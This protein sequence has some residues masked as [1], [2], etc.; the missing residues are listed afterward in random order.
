MYCFNNPKIKILL[1]VIDTRLDTT[2][3]TTS[4]CIRIKLSID[5]TIQDTAGDNKNIFCGGDR[6]QL[7][8][9]VDIIPIII[10]TLIIMT[11]TATTATRKKLCIGNNIT[12]AV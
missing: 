10:R 9:M 1:G 3:D 12:H 8:R 11:T 2:R 6:S 4:G 5:S 7:N